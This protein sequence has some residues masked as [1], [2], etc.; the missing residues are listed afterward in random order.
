MSGAKLWFGKEK[1]IEPIGK[2][3][4]E[5][6]IKSCP[7]HCAGESGSGW[8]FEVITRCD[9]PNMVGE[10][11]TVVKPSNKAPYISS[12]YLPTLFTSGLQAGSRIEATKLEYIYY[13]DFVLNTR[14]QIL[15]NWSEI[16][17]SEESKND[18]QDSINE[19]KSA[20][21]NRKTQPIIE[22]F[23]SRVQLV[24][25]KGRN[26]P[27]AT[28]AKF[29]AMAKRLELQ[30]GREN[31]SAGSMLKRR[32]FATRMLA[33]IEQNIWDMRHLHRLSPITVERE[34]KR[35][36][37]NSKFKPVLYAG[38]YVKNTYGDNLGDTTVLPKVIDCYASEVQLMAIRNLIADIQRGENTK[39]NLR[40]LKVLL[41][42]KPS[43]MVYRDI[44]ERISNSV[45]AI[46]ALLRNDDPGYKRI[47]NDTK[48][49]IRH[50]ANDD[51]NHPW[52]IKPLA[53]K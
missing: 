27:G 44:F 31:S 5:K 12:L 16:R 22:A 25:S 4:A 2:A 23:E 20:I 19:L 41:S 52:Y 11:I 28:S 48:R 17:L 6:H 50:R 45:I 37:D 53:P 35:R 32:R 40:I 33:S 38:T 51:P 24:D 49:S 9:D 8:K 30:I 13:L 34:L 29:T 47:C 7:V 21:H 46:E 36:I 10:I 14:Y 39:E 26:N 42:A 43:E 15:N 3:F 1:A 18:I